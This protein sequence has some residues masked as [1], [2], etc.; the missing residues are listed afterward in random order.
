MV[1][2]ATKNGIAVKEKAQFDP[3]GVPYFSIFG[4]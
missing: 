4:Y 3:I 1:L 2:I